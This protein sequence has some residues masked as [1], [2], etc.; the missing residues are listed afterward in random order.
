MFT[1]K[2][3]L[4]KVIHEIPQFI[5]DRDSLITW[6]W[7]IITPFFIPTKYLLFKE[8]LI[9]NDFHLFFRDSYSRG[10]GVQQL[11]R[12]A[13]RCAIRAQK[14]ERHVTDDFFSFCS[15]YFLLPH[16]ITCTFDV[17]DYLVHGYCSGRV[18]GSHFGIYKGQDK[19]ANDDC[20]YRTQFMPE[21]RGNISNQVRAICCCHTEQRQ[22]VPQMDIVIRLGCHI[23]IIIGQFPPTLPAIV[24]HHM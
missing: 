3:N 13:K 20:E 11:C 5:P 24:M 7:Y 8:A 22:H 14:I 19:H 4:W 18:V 16:Q 21:S 12:V 10:N 23:I 9:E 2:K 1:K 6:K 17:S 15:I